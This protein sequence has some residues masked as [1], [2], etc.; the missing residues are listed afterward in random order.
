MPP[1]RVFT[2][3]PGVPFLPTLAEALRSG[4]L[5]DG[6]PDG[7]EL[8]D[9]T[10]YLPTRRAGRALTE[11]LTEATGGRATLLP[12][13]VPLGDEDDPQE[14]AL[15]GTARTVPIPPLERRLILTRLVQAW[16]DRVRQ[17]GDGT[18]ASGTPAS[19]LALA[20]D[21]EKLMDSFALQGVPWSALHAAIEVEV[22]EYYELTL[23]FITIAQENWPR[24][25][26]D[27]G[28]CDPA[29]RRHEAVVQEAERLAA[30][31]PQGPIVA[32]GSTGSMP[33]TAKLLGAIARLPHG[34]VVLPGLDLT[35]DEAAWTAIAGEGGDPLWGHPQHMMR[36]L[37][38]GELGIDRAAVRELGPR[39]AERHPATARRRFVSEALR[40]AETTDSW[41]A[42]PQDDRLALVRDASQGLALIEADDEREEALAIAVALRETLAEPARTAALVTPDRMLARRVAAELGRWGIA[43]EDSAGCPVSGSD[44]GR[45]ARL[46]AD[47]A[48]GDFQPV[49]T[50]A[51]LAHPAVTLGQSRQD[52]VRAASALDIGALRGPAPGPGVEGL[53]AALDLRRQERGPRDPEPRRRLTDSDWDAASDL[54]NRLDAAFA[55]FRPQ[56]ED[57]TVDLAGLAALHRDALVAL[58][59]PAAGEDGP[60]PPGWRQLDELFD[61]LALAASSGTGLTGRIADYPDV[62]AALAFDRTVAPQAAGTHRR[63]KILGLLE[64]RLLDPDRIVLAGLDETIWPPKADTDAFLNRP[65]RIA[66]GLSPPER[67]IGQTAHDFAQALGT[68]D[69]ILTRAKKRDGK[70]TVP[71]RFIERLDAFASG[72]EA[73]ASVRLRGGWYR[74]LAAALERPRAVRPVSRPEPRPGG[75]RFP[76]RL[77]VTEIETLVRDPYG[78]YARHILRLDPLDP[79]ALPPAAAERGTILH[80]IVAVFAERYGTLEPGERETV[81]RE[82]GRA[83]L[84]SIA[85]AYPALHAL[86]MPEFERLAPPLAAWEASR[87]PDI[88]A[89]QLETRGQLAIRVSDEDRLVIRG[90]ADRIETSASGRSTVVDFKTGQPPSN[91]TIAVGFAP[92]LVMEAAMLMAGGFPGIAQTGTLPAM[93]YVKLGG[94]DRLVPRDIAPP[95]GDPRSMDQIV[96][97]HLDGLRALVSRYVLEDEGY[98]ARPFPQHVNAFSAY[99]HLARVKEWSVAGERDGDGA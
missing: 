62:F 18:A 45:L 49:A 44:A 64:A 32:A 83:A 31:P 61:D 16:Q 54:L 55:G 88:T 42:M 69:V 99:D 29:L 90:K 28:A 59:E 79:V 63:V 34:A 73:W 95:K 26:A 92:Q 19:S 41:A 91:P 46:A 58:M 5:T 76:G 15:G 74:T 39:H 3:P 30:D 56:A 77:S 38:A 85:A 53:R 10:L 9:A 82:I 6:W 89:L 67:R 36:R 86:W 97:A 65:M 20:G 81:L 24:I 72:S 60:E 71:S 70:P 47:V 51:L 98:R 84:T 21:L 96:T 35:L 23:D 75:H 40:P 80:A 66:L 2:I 87:R 94:R 33:A 22:S 17:S 12:R 7:T 37:L 78:I 11:I 52:T 93:L 8:A 43:T 14:P 13:I 57:P 50:T 27:R 1:P 4:I 68:A 25:L 48:A